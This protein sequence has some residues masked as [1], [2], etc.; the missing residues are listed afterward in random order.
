MPMINADGC[1]IHVEVEGPEGA[2][3]LMLSN[4]LGT[5]LHMWDP[6]VASFTQHFRARA[7][8]PAR[9]RQVRLPRGSL[10]HGDARPRRACGARRARHRK[11]ELVRPFH[12][13]HGRPVARRQRAATGSSGSSCPTPRAYFPDKSCWNDRHQDSCARRASPAIAAPN[14]ER[15]FT[16]DFRERAPE[17]V[18]WLQRDVRS[19]PRSKATSPAARR[20]ATWTT[21]RSCRTIKAPTLVIAGKHDPATTAEASEYH[22]RTTS[23]ARSSPLLDA[24]HISN[25]EQPHAYADDGA[26]I[27]AGG[28]T[29]G[30]RRGAR[31]WTT[32]NVI[33]AARTRADRCSAMPGSIAPTP[34][35]LPSMPNGR[36]SLPAVP[37]ARSGRGRIS[38]SAPGASSSSEP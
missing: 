32:R 11:D 2:P 6:Q 13:R 35:R 17:R 38:T 29:L 37:G 28:E 27:S 15:W 10:H 36:I 9:P 24:A 12:G 18:A 25:V 34:T 16:K 14:M 8:R 20:C 3:V 30:E 31:R 1:P 5:T 33:G 26:G 4:S 7:L 21:A 19:R 22:R 23:R